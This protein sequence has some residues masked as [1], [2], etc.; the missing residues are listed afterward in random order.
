MKINWRKV[1]VHLK[2]AL[3]APFPSTLCLTPYEALYR[4]WNSFTEHLL[5]PVTAVYTG[6]Y[7]G[8]QSDAVPPLMIETDTLGRH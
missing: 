7:G 3:A 8:V 5:V 6:G 2:P 1:V 4:A